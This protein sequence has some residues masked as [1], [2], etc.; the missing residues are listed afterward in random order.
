MPWPSWVLDENEFDVEVME[1][2]KKGL[3]TKGK[4]KI[5]IHVE[6]EEERRP[7]NSTKPTPFSK[8]SCVCFSR[9]SLRKWASRPARR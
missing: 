4:V 7:R 6:E 9:P 3:F 2:S 5:R 8:R 1:E